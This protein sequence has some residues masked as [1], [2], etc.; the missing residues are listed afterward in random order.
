MITVLFPADYFDQN[1]P[2]DSFIKEYR[3]AMENNINVLLF[4]YDTFLE[5]GKL[6]LKGDTSLICPV[7]Y[8]RLC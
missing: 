2:D 4:S 1:K 6:R 3:A 5:D 8:S 7:I